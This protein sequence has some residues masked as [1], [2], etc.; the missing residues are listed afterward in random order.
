MTP[1]PDLAPLA[2]NFNL[3]HFLRKLTLVPMVLGKRAPPMPPPEAR[4][5]MMPLTM[6]PG[7]YRK[8]QKIKRL[9]IL[10]PEAIFCESA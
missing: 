1:R 9:N 7:G 3:E 4:S 10:E 8:L 6:K 2:A 5:T